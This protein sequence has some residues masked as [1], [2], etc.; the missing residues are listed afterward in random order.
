MRFN[1]IQVISKMAETGMVPVFYHKDLETAKKVVKACYDGGV[2][3]FE[4]TNRGDF[5]H[6]IFTELV[7]HFA[8]ECPDLIL[9]IGSVVDA[10]TASLYLQLGANFIVGPYFNAE[11]A[12]VC[13]RRLVPYTPGAGSVTEIG[14]VQEAGCDV[15]KIFPAGNVGGPSFVKNVKGPLPWSLLMVTGAVEP[16]QENLTAWIKAGVTCVGM[17][18][19][20]FPEEDIHSENWQKITDRCKNAFSYIHQAKS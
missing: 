19:N 5:A 10:G 7:K 18:S 14:N 16:T 12:K 15:V 4:F 11:I 6:E 9:G 1:K 8:T 2:R 20:L 17:G 3:V 13:N